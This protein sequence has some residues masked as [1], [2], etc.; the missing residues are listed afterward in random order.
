MAA[1]VC[2]ELQ[3]SFGINM[4][5]SDFI[6]HKYVFTKL[7]LRRTLTIKKKKSRLKRFC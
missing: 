2:K 7:A 4:K 3:M 1:K 6:Y 5:Y